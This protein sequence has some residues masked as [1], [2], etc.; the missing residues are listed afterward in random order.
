[1]FHSL[2]VQRNRLPH[3]VITMP[4]QCHALAALV[5]SL[6]MQS[7]RLPHGVIIMP[8]ALTG[9]C[10]HRHVNR[11]QGKPFGRR[12]RQ[13]CTVHFFASVSDSKAVIFSSSEACCSFSNIHFARRCAM[14][15]VWWTANSG[16]WGLQVPY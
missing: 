2:S 7:N 5:C 11:P 1:M 15:Q 12:R 14:V 3:N 4:A 6:S 16:Y 8:A 10:S 13:I 9:L